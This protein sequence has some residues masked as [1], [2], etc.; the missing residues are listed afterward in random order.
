ME[1]HMTT[2]PSRCVLGLTLGALLAVAA[3]A[4]TPSNQKTAV[5]PKT[6]SPTQRITGPFNHENLTIFLI[7][8]EDRIKDKHFLTLKEALEKKQVIVHETQQVNELAIEN[9]SKTEEVF[10]QAG[11]IV[12]GGQ[13]DRVIAYDFLVPPKSG[14][15]PIASF[16]V[17]PG[18]WQ[19]RGNEKAEM[20]ESSGQQA[21]TR[22]LKK[23][24]REEMDQSKV[25]ERAG[26]FQR[27]L[28]E[29]GLI[30]SLPA[31]SPTS[32]QLTLENKKLAKAVEGYLKKLAPVLEGKNDV[33]GCAVA[34]NGAV[35]SADVYASHDLFLKVWPTLLKGS[36]VEALVESGT[37][38]DRD[39]YPSLNPAGG[40]GAG[41]PIGGL[42]LGGGG[43]AGIGGGIGGI[44]GALGGVGG[45]GIAGGTNGAAPAANRTNA[46]DKQEKR[47]PVKPAKPVTTAA[48]LAFLADAEKGQASQHDVTNR[49]R[50]VQHETPRT[51]LFISQDKAGTGGAV[52]LR[53]SY[54]AH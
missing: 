33:I 14:K 51:S 27:K 42:G 35:E 30:D 13:Q 12:K 7:H 26:Y 17:E 32:L 52:P 38:M 11:D 36:A 10:V 45:L 39:F 31:A 24:V 44:G 16:C 40:Q 28:Q 29:A 49:V 3:Q 34:V 6:D 4:Q 54:L 43:L 2:T 18:R 15:I 23:A 53:A 21:V 19:Q 20:F 25:W 50:L 1:K 8:G 46:A 5:P 37:G 22:G 48:V 47:K 41:A 9:L